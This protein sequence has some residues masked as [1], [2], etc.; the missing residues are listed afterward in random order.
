MRPDT[1]AETHADRQR[2]PGGNGWAA[3]VIRHQSTHTTSRMQLLFIDPEAT[4]RVCGD[5]GDRR[6]ETA[7]RC[8]CD[9]LTTCEPEW[10]WEQLL[11]ILATLE[12]MLC[13][14]PQP[15]EYTR[16]AIGI[17]PFHQQVSLA[18]RE[19]EE[20]RL[21]QPR[22]MCTVHRRR[23]AQGSVL[24]HFPLPMNERAW[25]AQEEPQRARIDKPLWT[26][27]TPSGMITVDLSEDT[28]RDL[29]FDDPVWERAGKV[30]MGDLGTDDGEDSSDSDNDQPWGQDQKQRRLTIKARKFHWIMEGWTGDKQALPAAVSKASRELR[31]DK[32]PM[33]TLGWDFLLALKEE[34]GSEVITGMSALTVQPMFRFTHQQWP[35]TER[36][37]WPLRGERALMLWPTLTAEER[38][39]VVTTPTGE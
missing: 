7:G 25:T 29:Q 4:T 28:R 13:N 2:L 5:C 9:S 19:E 38:A 34:T 27:P 16:E 30:H 22:A 24:S 39:D 1:W 20:D 31:T 26:Q 36:T 3:V 12:W 37:A 33:H 18:R 23:Q 10:Q 8:E 14:P 17:R 6:W 35:M 11:S 15:A 32:E 21:E